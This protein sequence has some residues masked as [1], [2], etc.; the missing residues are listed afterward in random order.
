MTRLPAARALALAALTGSLCLPAHAASSQAWVLRNR[1]D[2][3]KADLSGVSLA[4]EG[5][6]RLSAQVTPLL[7]AAQP[8]IWCLARD[9]QGALYAGSGNEGKVF[10]ITPGSGK[11]E[12]VF[13]ANEL[14]I[15]ALTFDKEGRLYAATSPRGAVYRVGAGGSSEVVF[16]P[17]EVYIWAIAFDDR[18]RLHVATGQRG[19]VFRVD[20][21]GPKA[22]G[23]VELDGREDHIR[24]LVRGAGGTF[25]AGTDQSGIV[26]AIPPEGPATVVYDTPMRE[27]SAIAVVGDALYVA[28]LAPV[29]RPRGGG[30]PQQGGGVTRVTVTADDAP[31]PDQPGSERQGEDQSDQAR[32]Q[33]T[34][35]RTQPAGE[36]YYGAIY[37]I[38]SSGYARRIWESRDAL[39]LSLA[40][41]PDRDGAAQPGRILVGTGNEG[42]VLLLDDAGE[43]TDYVE[44][45][46]SQVNAL[47]LAPDGRNGAGLYAGAS[48]LGQVAWISAA[49]SESGTVTSEVL[50]A[51]FT[52]SWG[53]IS[54]NGDI[55][56]GS[57]VHMSVRTGN[58]EEPDASWSDW[59]R[60]YAQPSGSL[61][62]RPRARYLQWRATL[63]AGRGGGPTLRSVQINYLQDNLPPEVES[64]EIQQPGVTLMGG[65]GI[66]DM[67]DAGP[68][69][70]PQQQPRRGF[71]RGR[72]AALWKAED[73]NGDEI[74]Y[75][76][77]F[78]AEDET[79]WKPLAKDL[80]D[81]FYTWD[82]TA[83]PDGVYRVRVLATDGPSN[84]EGAALT[85]ALI[86][87][88]FDVDNTPPLVAAP[89]AKVS[90]RTAEVSVEV[91]DSF[92][93]VGETAWS[94][95]AADWVV[96]LPEDRIADSRQERYRFRTP[97]LQP[98]EHTITLRAEDR[99]GN[100][101]AS[102]V[103]IEVRP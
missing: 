66:S 83:L 16:D 8:S 7:D 76:L 77:F 25:Y 34:Q 88:A 53:M 5:A 39:P 50:D 28:A 98:G 17:E 43:A 1:N 37:R 52:S 100:V 57:L 20:A 33:Q 80:S 102:K 2:F 18:G 70:R 13:D 54:W 74:H 12:V 46:A 58:T 78:K 94:L 69:R 24:T 87:E 101:A 93:V 103:V 61:I 79:L 89:Q 21:P 19:R 32:P 71:D 55:P 64:I 30:Q 48:N 63:R 90:G 31:A 42:R 41:Y 67:P 68:G 82:A 75:D 47:L 56:G 15:H 6:L 22:T 86:S 10:K 51:G 60:E 38:G 44:I 35:Q 92:S 95:D 85:G 26:Y 97:E 72:R 40:P 45:G 3:V 73:V 27:V 91:S 49:G 84:P 81:P 29:S 9:A 65:G 99:A 62:E 4:P 11:S 36:A 14:Q 23:V 59:S 96:V